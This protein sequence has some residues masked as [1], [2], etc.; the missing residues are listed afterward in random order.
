MTYQHLP[1]LSAPLQLIHS[2]FVSYINSYQGHM[3]LAPKAATTDWES[4]KDRI[5]LFTGE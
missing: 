4:I 1:F 5:L 2:H 3:L